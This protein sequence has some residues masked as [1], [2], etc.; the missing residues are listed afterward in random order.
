M[1]TLVGKQMLAFRADKVNKRWHTVAMND[2]TEI[3]RRSDGTRAAILAAA[4]EHFATSGYQGAT[5][6]AIAASAGIDPSMVMRYYGNK[7]KLF[8]AAAEFDLKLPDLSGLPRE[9]VG[10]ALVE[11]FL[12]RWE[13]DESL[14]V[15]LRSA[16]TNEAAAKRVQAIF[17]TQ[18][19][20][21]ISKLSGE[22]KP[23]AAKRA[24]LIASQILGIALCRFVLK[25]PPVV[26]LDREEVVRRVGAT[27]NSYL[28]ST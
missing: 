11:H 15:L 14:M 25:L 3:P 24:G 9:Q 16:V 21:T 4:R 28:Y 26:S 10:P 13:G 18:T 5:I 23:L 19:A 8:A 22:S 20:P 7:E 2:T 1:S 12:A 27:I 6:R 17:S